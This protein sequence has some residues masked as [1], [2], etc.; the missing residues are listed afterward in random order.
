MIIFFDSPKHLVIVCYKILIKSFFLIKIWQY[1]SE[2]KPES[3]NIIRKK[4]F[5][6]IVEKDGS[7]TFDFSGLAL[8]RRVKQHSIDKG[9]FFSA[10][11][12]YFCQRN[13]STLIIIYKVVLYVF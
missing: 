7:I 8:V 6:F 2:E 9:A 13:L 5:H 11:S 4:L 12:K 1:F 3:N 10:T